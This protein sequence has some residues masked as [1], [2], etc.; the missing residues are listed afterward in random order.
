MPE[1]LLSVKIRFF[2]QISHLDVMSCHC[3]NCQTISSILIM[4]MQHRGH[5]FVGR[6]RA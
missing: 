4:Q 3:W 2:G 6:R 1:Y 5:G